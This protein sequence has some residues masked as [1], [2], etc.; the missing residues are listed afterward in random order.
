MEWVLISTQVIG[1]Q[2]F[3]PAGLASIPE[4]RY[5]LRMSTDIAYRLAA[6]DRWAEVMTAGVF[7]G[8]PHD[9]AD[10]FIHLSAA[11]QIEGTLIKHYD[12]HDH[13]VLVEIDLLQLGDTVKWEVSRDDEKFPHVYGTIPVS[14]VRGV[15]HVLRNADGEWVLPKEALE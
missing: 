5:L 4:G 7:N 10:G 13:L 11:T 15:R 2:S 6:P 12:Q 8:E 3:Y 1:K 14:A 9:V